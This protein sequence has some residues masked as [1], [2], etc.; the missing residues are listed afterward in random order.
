M[1]DGTN[2]LNYTSFREAARVEGTCTL[3]ELINDVQPITYT[4]ILSK[5]RIR[6]WI[7]GS[8]SLIR[9]YL[10]SEGWCYI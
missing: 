7:A 1:L 2:L 8:Y 6:P 3:S 9:R 4:D 10:C 5:A